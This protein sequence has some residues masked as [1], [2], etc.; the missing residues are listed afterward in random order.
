L[1]ATLVLTVAQVSATL[2][3]KTVIGPGNIDLHDGAEALLDGHGERGVRLTLRGLATAD[4]AREEKIAHANLCAG[5][6]MIDKPDTALEHCNWVL[7]RYDN[8]WR[9]YNNRALVYLRLERYEEA[10]ADIR[11]G[12][13]LRPNSTKLKIV[14]GLY[15]DVTEP[16]EARVEVD[17]RRDAASEAATDSGVDG[18]P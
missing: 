2:E 15:M 4:S 7:E 6:L 1:L 14:K 8:H 10:E 16:V 3:S 9:T 5:F 11:Q 17:D 18:R 12:Q 13:A